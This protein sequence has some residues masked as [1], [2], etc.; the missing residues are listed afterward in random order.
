VEGTEAP[1]DELAL[2]EGSMGNGNDARVVQAREAE[3]VSDAQGV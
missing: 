1:Q 3:E 2:E